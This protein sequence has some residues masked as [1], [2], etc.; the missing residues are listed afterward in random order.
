MRNTQQ[1]MPLREEITERKQ[2]R[3]NNY[4]TAATTTAAV[5]D[6][7]FDPAYSRC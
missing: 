6:Q 5:G 1:N 2:R 7:I 4:G 3:K